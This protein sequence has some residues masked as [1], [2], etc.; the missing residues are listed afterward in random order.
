[1]QI[2]S[3]LDGDQNSTNQDTDSKISEISENDS[4][5]DRSNDSSNGNSNSQESNDNEYLDVSD[6]CKLLQICQDSAVI[7]TSLVKS[8]GDRKLIEIIETNE[9]ICTSTPPDCISSP[10]QCSFVISLEQTDFKISEEKKLQH[11][12]NEFSSCKN[13]G[14]SEFVDSSADENKTNAKFIKE[15]NEIKEKKEVI[16]K[17]IAVSVE[18]LSDNDNDNIHVHIN[19]LKI[20]DQEA[21]LVQEKCTDHYK[22]SE[23][24]IRN[25]LSKITFFCENVNKLMEDSVGE[26]SDEPIQETTQIVEKSF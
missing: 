4:S 21:N 26:E 25:N 17:L 3:N 12:F 22:D 23:D 18:R 8:N 11:Q 5:D 1:M 20:S 2:P 16:D 7:E 15:I 24:N 19:A 9:A 14:I 10:S 13:N 6:D